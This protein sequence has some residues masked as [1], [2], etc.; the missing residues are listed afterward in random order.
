MSAGLR[1]DGIR[2]AMSVAKDI[3]EGRLDPTVLGSDFVQEARELF[4]R[5]VG[6]GDELWALQADV[7]RQVLAL[8]GVPAD[9]LA[10][11][12][13]LTRNRETV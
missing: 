2:A 8:G 5:V 7:A 13:A 10:E 9:E 1:R 11:W 6:P 3:A 12:L 4:G